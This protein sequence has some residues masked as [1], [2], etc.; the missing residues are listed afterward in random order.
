MAIAKSFLTAQSFWATPSKIPFIPAPK[1]ASLD[2]GSPLRIP[3][4]ILEEPLQN[5]TPEFVVDENMQ[6]IM[7]ALKKDKSK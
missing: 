7:S 5:P 1:I 6:L 4:D 2:E 3:N